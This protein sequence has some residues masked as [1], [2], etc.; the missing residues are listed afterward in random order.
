MGFEGLQQLQQRKVEGQQQQHALAAP[1]DGSLETY[2]RK[3]SYQHL[4]LPRNKSKELQP[5]WVAFSLSCIW[6][7]QVHGVDI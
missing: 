1:L 5:T 6:H 3:N 4:N 2:S 7:L